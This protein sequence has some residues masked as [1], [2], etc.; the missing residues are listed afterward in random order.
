[1]QVAVRVALTIFSA[2]FTFAAAA[3]AAENA[4]AGPFSAFSN[5]ADGFAVH[6]NASGIIFL[7]AACVYAIAA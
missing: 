6:F 5:A 2:K 1:L 7:H 4:S 3:A